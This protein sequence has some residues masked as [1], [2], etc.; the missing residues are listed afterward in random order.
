VNT[1]SVCIPNFNYASYIGETIGSVLDQADDRV[2]VLV[3][4]NAS[5]DDSVAVVEAFAD[6]RVHV[7]VNPV[8]VGFAGNL[9]RAAGPARGDVMILL[10]SDDV[11]LPGALERYRT[12]FDRAGTDRLVVSATMQVIDGEGRPTGT[13]GPEPALWE[14]ARHATELE[15]AID[16]TVLEL[17]PPELLR[18]SVS[19][20]LNPFNFAAT[21]YPRAIY[22]EVAGYGAGR[23][24]NPDKWFHWRLVER[25]ERVL[26][27]D[28]PLFGYRWHDSNQAALE[29]AAGVF[30]FLVDD[31][32]NTFDVPTDLLAS[33]GLTR[34]DLVAA[35]IERD[36]A[37]HG[38]A[39]L[40]RG[41]VA[42][43]R[44]T[45]HFGLA[46]YPDAFRHNPR[47]QALRALA[48][49]GP[50]GARLAKLAYRRYG[51]GPLDAA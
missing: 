51:P 20:L 44:R 9:D 18:R 45:A 25:A 12:L 26:W 8:N 40:A 41:H 21:A 1:F 46:A 4:D 49:L 43:A 31:Y 22:E 33:I 2:E 11:M 42:R 37:N 16:A 47:A 36:I 28:T 48:V 15:A 34:D 27:V 7:R 19:Q 14:G 29:S 23:L 17:D 10:S 50:V 24:Y 5:T 3:S 30:R 32:V 38:L 13:R 6:P 39:T 35:F